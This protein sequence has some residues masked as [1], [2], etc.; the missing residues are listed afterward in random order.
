MTKSKKL[1]SGNYYQVTLK[2]GKIHP[3]LFRDPQRAIRSVGVENVLKLREVLKEQVN[4][5]YTGVDAITGTPEE[6]L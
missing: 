3:K 6:S 2:N 1:D 4:A 5:N